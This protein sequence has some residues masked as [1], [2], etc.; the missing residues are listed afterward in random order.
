MESDDLIVNMQQSQRQLEAERKLLEERSR[1]ADT[2]IRKH[3]DLIRDFETNRGRLTQEAENEAYAVLNDARRLVDES[4][5]EIRRETASKQSVRAALSH[6]SNAKDELKEK[7]RQ[8]AAIQTNA[9]KTPPR[10]EVGDKVRLKGLS[11][12]GEVLRISPDRNTP[13]TLLIANMQMQISYQD[14]EQVQPQEKNNRIAP[15]VVDVQRG[16]ADSVK[17]E[18]HLLGYT[19]DEA[20]EAVDKYL[21]DAF[22]ASLPKVRIVHGKG[23][24][25]LRQGIHEGL[26]GHPLVTSFELAPRSEGGDGATV[27]TLKE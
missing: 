23:T 13:I 7:Q 16:K 26:I 6:I 2:S 24:G 18:L 3:E 19:V 15:S 5:A 14:I 11:N 12:Y 25:A 8:R 10:V 21:D 22:L 1:A 20:L 17:T 27:V 9:A 4:I